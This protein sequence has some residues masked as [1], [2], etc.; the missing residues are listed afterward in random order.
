M[1][2]SQRKTPTGRPRLG[3]FPLCCLSATIQDATPRHHVLLVSPSESTIANLCPCGVGNVHS[4]PVD[5]LCEFE[6]GPLPFSVRSCHVQVI[7]Y[8]HYGPGL[9]LGMGIGSGSG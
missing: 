5:Y 6:G 4:C 1:P 8:A 9:R 3:H 2:D 7:F